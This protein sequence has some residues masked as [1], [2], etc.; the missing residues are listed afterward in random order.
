MILIHGLIHFD[1]A[2]STI[3]ADLMCPLLLLR[4]AW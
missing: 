2:S 1:Q 4:V 3:L